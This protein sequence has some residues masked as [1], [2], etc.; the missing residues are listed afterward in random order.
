[1]PCPEQ[2]DLPS[3]RWWNY[4]K[5][6]QLYTEK[7]C[8]MEAKR[9]F[10][11]AIEQR[12]DDTYQARTYGL[13]FI[14]YFPHRELGIAYYYLGE[15]KNAILELQRSLEFVSVKESNKRA[16]EFLNRI[17]KQ[18]MSTTILPSIDLNRSAYHLCSKHLAKSG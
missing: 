16:D 12:H 9:D 7:K 17:K 18:K 13:N 15:Y 11:I 6:G 2:L 3:P 1:M 8:W 4:Y 14:D 5:R 10:E